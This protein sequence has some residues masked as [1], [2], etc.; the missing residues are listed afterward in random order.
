MKS[1]LLHL[2]Q[3]YS[4]LECHVSFIQFADFLKKEKR[5]EGHVINSKKS[6]EPSDLRFDRKT[7]GK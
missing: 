1:Y 3:F 5:W 7:Q 6:S 4:F 2:K